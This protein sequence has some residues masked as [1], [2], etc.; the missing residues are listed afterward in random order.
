M[1]QHVRPQ[2]PGVRLH[3][4][5]Y[6]NHADHG[7]V[8]YLCR[9]IRWHWIEIS[10]DYTGMTNLIVGFFLG[11]AA[12]TIGFTGIAKM[13]DSSVQKVQKTMIQIDK[14]Q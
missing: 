5:V 12:A 1:L 4:A 14:E 10:G 11:I 8:H 7:H 6:F 13:A 2:K 3:D 9:H